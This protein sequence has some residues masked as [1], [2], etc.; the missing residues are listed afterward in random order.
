[1]EAG[2]TLDLGAAPALPSLT[3]RDPSRT[4]L[5]HMHVRIHWTTADASSTSS[6]SAI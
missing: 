5:S 6:R 2:E 1:M 4:G 3:G